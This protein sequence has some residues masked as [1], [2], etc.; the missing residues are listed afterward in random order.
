MLLM[1]EAWQ[2]YVIKVKHDIITSFWVLF[3]HFYKDFPRQN[4]Q[5]FIGFRFGVVNVNFNANQ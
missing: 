5:P 1:N 3:K 2:V 4:M